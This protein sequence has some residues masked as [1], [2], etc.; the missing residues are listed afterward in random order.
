MRMY[1]ASRI[2]CINS[3]K[4]IECH[5]IVT[6]DHVLP[7]TIWELQFL[8]AGTS[9]YYSNQVSAPRSLSQSQGNTKFAV[10]A[11][12]SQCYS[13][14]QSEESSILNDVVIYALRGWWPF[15]SF[16][17]QSCSYLHLYVN[18][19]AWFRE[20]LLPRWGVPDPGGCLVPG[21]GGWYPSMHWDRPPLWTEWQTG[22]KILPCPKLRLRAVK[23]TI[24]KLKVISF[25]VKM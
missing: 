4:K 16:E 11:S 5:L 7:N 21:G 13:R 2:N 10:I 24:C 3:C 8:Y 9:L 17:R 15:D 1:L 18:R 12:H 20:G 22:V 14:K 25:L 19:G 6:G 23:I